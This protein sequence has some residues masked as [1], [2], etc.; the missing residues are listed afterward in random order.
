VSKPC[1]V[2]GQET[3]DDGYGEPV[4]VSTGRY[5]GPEPDGYGHVARVSNA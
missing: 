4:H 3:E 1:L 2:C 5:E